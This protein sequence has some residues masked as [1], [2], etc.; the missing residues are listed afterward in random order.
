MQETKNSHGFQTE[1]A[2]SLY[3]TLGTETIPPCRTA[4]CQKMQARHQLRRNPAAQVLKNH[5][6]LAERE[7]A[8]N[9]LFRPAWLH[10]YR[11]TGGTYSYVPTL[12]TA[13]LTPYEH[14]PM[15]TSPSPE[16]KFITE[17]QYLELCKACDQILRAQIPLLSGWQFPGCMLLGN[18]RHFYQNTWQCLMRGKT[19][20]CFFN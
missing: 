17:P 13:T 10:I 11:N 7:C 9:K 16:Q 20:N 2:L 8:T 18:T 1:A 19:C 6:L 12:E 5:S 3:R 14:L 15:K 4:P